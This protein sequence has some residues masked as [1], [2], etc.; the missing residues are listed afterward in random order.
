[1]KLISKFKIFLKIWPQKCKKKNAL[2]GLFHTF[3]KNSNT[4]LLPGGYPV[5]K[6]RVLPVPDPDPGLW[7][8]D[9]T[10]TRKFATWSNTRIHY[11][12]AIWPCAFSFFPMTVT[13]GVYCCHKMSNWY[14]YIVM[15]LPGFLAVILHQSSN[16]HFHFLLMTP[17]LE[18]VEWPFDFDFRD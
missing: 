16:L 8:L 1:M 12:K 11:V 6:F 18:L 4:R 9:P 5:S 3:S 15:I 14:H 17:S 7:Y 13:I 2:E 10:R